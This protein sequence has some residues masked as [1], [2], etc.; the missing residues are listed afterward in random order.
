M[1]VENKKNKKIRKITAICISL[2]FLNPT[3]KGQPSSKN[4]AI[5]SSALCLGALIMHSFL[6]KAEDST[7]TEDILLPPTKNKIPIKKDYYEEINIENSNFC[8]QE[9]REEGLK[10]LNAILKSHIISSK[11]SQA[12]K[13]L[14]KS[15]QS[16]LNVL[17]IQQIESQNSGIYDWHSQ[18]RHARTEYFSHLPYKLTQIEDQDW[19]LIP[20]LPF[21]TQHGT[22]ELASVTPLKATHPG[23]AGFIV[24]PQKFTSDN[25]IIVSFTGTQSRASQWRD[26][27]GFTNFSTNPG[28]KSI[29][30]SQDLILHQVWEKISLY[31][32]SPYTLIFA[33]HSLG[34]ADAQHIA[35]AFTRSLLIKSQENSDLFLIFQRIWVCM[36]NSAGIPLHLSTQSLETLK[37]IQIFSNKASHVINL[38]IS[39]VLIDGDGVQL[40]GEGTLWQSLKTKN[41]DI[42]VFKIRYFSEQNSPRWI[43]RILKP[44]IITSGII[45]F[46][47]TTVFTHIG[48]TTI[49]ML[50]TTIT[51]HRLKYYAHS[52]ALQISSF[53]EIELIQGQDAIKLL[54]NKICTYHWFEFLLPNIPLAQN[55]SLSQTSKKGEFQK[56]NSHDWEILHD[57]WE[58]QKY[59]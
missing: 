31:T 57:P 22:I 9:I 25:E 54:S 26:T 51:S 28:Y 38:R 16:T 20:G 55:L 29:L 11:S 43:H 50:R 46:P 15:L 23:I 41:V 30:G 35:E 33:G 47:F 2:I 17:R 44:A 13:S 49:E 10:P 52:S 19:E 27:E 1:T 18:I 34:G 39:A 58:N 6:K 24:I 4:L 45:M 3:V 8:S 56:M 5:T 59:E 36:S 53:A 14:I 7:S 48:S 37:K 12:L 21:L 42:E 40:T 32:K